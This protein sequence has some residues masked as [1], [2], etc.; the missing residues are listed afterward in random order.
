LPAPLVF[1]ELLVPLE[2]L[3]VWLS[4]TSANPIPQCGELA[5]VIIEVEMVHG[6]ASSAIDDGRIRN[7]FTVM[8]HDGPNVDEHKEED[9]G[10]LLQREEEGKHMIRNGLREPVQR[11]ERMRRIWCWHNPFMVRLVDVFVD[12]WMVLHSVNPIN[13]EVGKEEEERELQDIVPQSRTLLGG[14]VH[15]AV[16]SNLCQEDGSCTQRHDG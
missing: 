16:S 10:K 1:A 2:E 13:E 14:V 15:L 12:N 4:V 5:I 9:V 11:M 7:I 6:M 8:N 3:L